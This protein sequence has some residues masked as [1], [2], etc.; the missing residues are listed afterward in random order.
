MLHSC[1]FDDNEEHQVRVFKYDG[2]AQ[3][4]Q[5][6][7]PLEIM[8]L[9]LTDAG[10][11][12]YSASC[13]VDGYNYAAA[14]GVGTGR[15]NTYVI[16]KAALSQ[17]QSLD[18][19]SVDDIPEY[20]LSTC[21]NHVY[22]YQN[23]GILSCDAGSGISLEDMALQLTNNGV[24]VL[25]S[26]CGNDGLPYTAVCGGTTGWINIY[27]V[28]SNDVNQALLLG[29]NSLDTSGSYEFSSCILP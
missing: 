19:N 21:Q 15:I 10:I 20:Q 5:T 26:S 2:S 17:A 24:S 25:S 1:I 28:S 7:T 27:E 18:Y 14:C 29:F 13:G 4:G 11:H 16:D 6:G 12:V 23:A 8:Q 22:V 9:E 3:C